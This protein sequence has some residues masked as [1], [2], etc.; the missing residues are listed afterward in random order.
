V[1]SFQGIMAG[2]ASQVGTWEPGGGAGGGAGTTELMRPRDPVGTCRVVV[3]GSR[4]ADGVHPA[5]T[6]GAYN[7]TGFTAFSPD[8][9]GRA[10]SY[11]LRGV[12]RKDGKCRDPADPSREIPCPDN[13]A[14]V[15]HW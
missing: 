8:G 12:V 15:D 9:R 13:F 2:W 5:D 10:D 1:L 3:N 14:Y 11:C 4:G 7:T 6:R